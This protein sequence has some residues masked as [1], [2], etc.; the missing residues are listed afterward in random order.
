VAQVTKL[1]AP[2]LALGVL[3]WATVDAPWK[4]F[5]A[6]LVSGAGWAATCGVALN[7]IVTPWFD[8][9]RPAALSLAYNGGSIGGLIFPTIWAVAI[10]FLGFPRAALIV[11]ALMTMTIWMLAGRFFA[12][13]PARMGLTPDGD[14]STRASQPIIASVTIPLP[15]GLLWRNR[16]FITLAVRMALGFFAQFGMI[17]HLFSL[18]VPALGTQAA[19]VALG[20]IGL[21]A[22][23]GR[24]VFA[25]LLVPGRDRRVAAAFNLGVQILG[26]IVFAASGESVFLLLTGVVL[27]GLGLG[28]GASLPPLIA[29]V[30]FTKDDVTRAV[31]AIIGIAQ[32]TSAFGPMVF[33]LI[34]DLMVGC[35][36]STCGNAPLVF[37]TAALIQ[38]LAC[39][40][41]LIGRR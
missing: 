27:F 30:E 9:K 29:Q 33:G 12:M 28:N 38:F 24:Q 4:L 23:L 1:G 2:T 5:V 16:R 10:N 34:R 17:A 36:G 37:A 39:V 32:A 3:G 20:A 40:C 8:R 25:K 14:A 31:P 26:S 11:G 15:G 19:G 13:S 6:S 18:L 41:F 21:A 7:A 22:I 35:A